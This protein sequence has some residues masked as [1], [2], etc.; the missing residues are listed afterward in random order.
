MAD[1]IPAN[2]SSLAYVDT[3]VG[4]QMT[5]QRTTKVEYQT[6][7]GTTVY[8]KILTGFKPILF[9][10]AVSR[11]AVFDY[12]FSIKD[13]I[14]PRE[15]PQV[16]DLYFKD[17][18]VKIQDIF[19]QVMAQ[20]AVL[21]GAILSYM[22]YSAVLAQ[23]GNGIETEEH[24][25]DGKVHKFMNAERLIKRDSSPLFVVS[26]N[27]KFNRSFN[28]DVATN[29]YKALAIYNEY[30]NGKIVKKFI[31]P[32]VSASVEDLRHVIYGLDKDEEEEMKNGTFS[33]AYCVDIILCDILIYCLKSFNLTS[34]TFEDIMG[35]EVVDKIQVK[36]SLPIGWM[37]PEEKLAE[38]GKKGTFTADFDETDKPLPNNLFQYVDM[39]ER[40]DKLFENYRPGNTVFQD[41]KGVIA[42]FV[43][44]YI[45]ANELLSVR[46]KSDN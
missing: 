5:L 27:L 46:V 17:L 14:L 37:T 7:N 23:D 19:T 13:L 9:P 15:L 41:N 43:G 29:S 3:P 12:R 40:C 16:T 25:I 42:D 34:A 22:P 35:P 38:F 2:T 31:K 32:T 39:Q 10:T 36:R 18:V 45:L 20:N 1:E 21:D 24:T 30:V 4:P 33:G 26:S 11:N 8:D 44:H 28:L 6:S